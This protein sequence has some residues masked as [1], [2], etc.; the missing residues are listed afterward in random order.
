MSPRS[1]KLVSRKSSLLATALAF[2]AIG[3]TALP[4]AALPPHLGGLSPRNAMMSAPVQV[5]H[6]VGNT[7]PGVGAQIGGALKQAPHQ[8]GKTLPGAG[9]QIG[10][11]LK[12]TPHQVGPTVP[13]AGSQIGGLLNQPPHQVGPSVPGAGSQIGALLNQPPHQVGPT[14]P[15][16]GSQLGG[17]LNQPPH[18]VG[19]TLPGAGSQLGG[20]LNQ[21]PHQVGPTLPGAGPQIGG[22]LNQPPN[23][24]TGPSGP[25]KPV[26]DVCPF[27][28]LKCQKP[29]PVPTGNSGGTPSQ[30]PGSMP[31]IPG[32]GL[33]FPSGD[34]GAVA[35][36][37]PPAFDQP[38]GTAATATGVARR[39]AT[40][41]TAP[42]NCL[43]KQ[44]LDDGSVLFR[45][46]CTKEA[47]VATPAEEAQIK[48]ALAR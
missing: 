25:S 23:V 33:S 16:A 48:A 6:V 35:S 20:L 27:N 39:P 22:I 26:D 42:C 21:P 3:L 11:I 41:A 40:V 5:P 43:T 9:A 4:A 13:G 14:L 32:G 31:S 47:A 7:L 38:D 15:G 12:Q 1:T 34:G 28:P 8:V 19:P 30:D 24:I 45:D 17:L 18:Q 37:T 44:Y 2:A 10:G 29:D 36:F 46:L